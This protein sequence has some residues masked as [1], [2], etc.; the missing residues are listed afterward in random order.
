MEVL[1]HFR[2]GRFVDIKVTRKDMKGVFFFKRIQVNYLHDRVSLAF[3]ER[4]ITWQVTM[5]NIIRNNERNNVIKFRLNFYSR[6][7][8]Y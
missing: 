6:F 8:I 5:S 2:P 7:L 3:T 4:Y 1:S